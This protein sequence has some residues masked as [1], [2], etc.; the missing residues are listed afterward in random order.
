MRT[1]TKVVMDRESVEL[2][3]V[4]AALVIEMFADGEGEVAEY[5][6]GLAQNVFDS[7]R[8]PLLQGES[9]G[10]TMRFVPATFYSPGYYAD[11]VNVFVAGL[12]ENVRTENPGLVAM[13]KTIAAQ[14]DS[15]AFSVDYRQSALD[16]MDG[17]GQS[18]VDAAS[19]K[20]EVSCDG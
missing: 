15:T 12:D 9:P 3:G 1:P 20:E 13:L 11:S 4:L 19:D 6:V 7:T 5:M 16:A 17:I 10:R 18:L 14:V 2:A 8:Y